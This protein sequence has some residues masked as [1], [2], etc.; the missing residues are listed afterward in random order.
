[1]ENTEVK[2]NNNQVALLKPFDKQKQ[3]L[4]KMVK[5]YAN[6]VVTEDTYEE[7][8][9]VRAVFRDTRVSIEKILKHNKSILNGLKGTQEEMAQELIDIISPTED[10]IDAGIKMIEQKKELDKKRKEEEAMKKLAARQ[11]QLSGYEMKYD[12]GSYTLGDHTIT[13]VQLKVFSDE[14]FNEFLELV[15]VEHE[16]IIDIRLQ[17]EAEKKKEAE[18]LEAQR[19]EQEAENKRLQD[20]EAA[21]KKQE[22]EAKAEQER[23]ANE[24]RE[25]EEKAKKESEEKQRKLDEERM[26]FLREKRDTRIYQLRDVGLERNTASTGYIFETV[27]ISDKEID[28]LEAKQWQELVSESKS[29]V[30]S[31]KQIAEQK[32]LEEE[33]EKKRQQALLEEHRIKRAEALRPDK[34][35]IAAYMK[36]LVE[37]TIP[38]VADE[39]AKVILADVAEMIVGIENHVQ[40]KLENI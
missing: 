10:T 24:T 34:E 1:M 33:E 16:K 2:E 8:K 27:F 19:R 12:D 37:V 20:K 17:A 29:K 14:E 28:E 13:A 6:V 9:K 39:Q 23:I 31:L 25:R 30:S 32:K 40:Q 5:E 18:R 4:Q 11:S 22:E 36:S 38:E 15:R 21:L 26:A 7:S 35:K 3:E